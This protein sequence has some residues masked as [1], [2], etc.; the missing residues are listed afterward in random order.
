M[1]FMECRRMFVQP[2]TQ[3]SIIT[4]YRRSPSLEYPTGPEILRSTVLPPSLF[5]TTVPGYY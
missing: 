4:A 3:P 5:F 1:A 2:A